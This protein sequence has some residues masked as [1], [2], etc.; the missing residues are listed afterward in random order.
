M[1]VKMKQGGIKA[2]TSTVDSKFDSDGDSEYDSDKLID[3]LS[4][5]KEELIELRNMMKAN[6]EAKAKGNSVLEINEPNDENSMPADNVR[7][8]TFK[9]HDI[10]MNML[11]KRLKTIDEDG[12]TQNPFIFVEENVE[13]FWH[14]ISVGGN[15]FEVRLGSEGFT[16][17]EGN[18]TCSCK[19][20]QLSGIPCVHVTN[21][22]YSS[23]LPPKPKKMPGMTRKKRIRPK[24]EGAS[25]T[26]VS[27]IGTMRDGSEQGGN[28]RTQH[29]SACAGGAYRSGC[30]RKV[31]S[32]AGTQKR[33]GKKRVGTSGF[34]IWFRLQDEP[35]QT[36]DDPVHIQDDPVQTQVDPVHTQ[37]Q[38]QV[39]QTQE[40]AEI[41]L[42]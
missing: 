20:W 22:M 27:K 35:V 39:E 41:D 13:K 17:D 31:V 12:K 3:Y 23:V 15:L 42:T 18:K 21:S 37:D 10:H 38:D 40:L 1:L 16:L 33:Q 7:G 32:S 19:M 34:S 25:S 6:R 24:S 5:S 14:V 4:L 29:G 28:G 8:E 2:R 9:K 26:R 30:K 11:L 36:Q